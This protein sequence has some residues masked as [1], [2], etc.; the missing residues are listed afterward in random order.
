MLNE[1]YALAKSLE[2]CGLNPPTY[3]PSLKSNP[4]KS[5]FVLGIQDDGTIGFVEFCEAQKMRE[6]RRIESSSNGVHYRTDFNSF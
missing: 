1:L 4:K 2:K 5:G 3:H 6:V